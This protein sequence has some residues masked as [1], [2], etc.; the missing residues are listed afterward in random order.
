MKDALETVK[1]P[2][3]LLK[4]GMEGMD[5][6]EGVGLERTLEYSATRKEATTDKTRGAAL[7]R[8]SPK[9]SLKTPKIVSGL[10]NCSVISLLLP[11]V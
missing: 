11:L 3:E 4:A 10:S 2:Y 8:N 7:L 9:T 6:T 1:E 5:E